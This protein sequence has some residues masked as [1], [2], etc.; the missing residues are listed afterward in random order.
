M[1]CYIAARARVVVGMA[2]AELVGRGPR[3]LGGAAALPAPRSPIR[4]SSSWTFSW[5]LGRHPTDRNAV[6][7]AVPRSA[8]LQA[9]TAPGPLDPG[10]GFP[11]IHGD[12]RRNPM[13]YGVPSPPSYGKMPHVGIHDD[14]SQGEHCISILTRYCPCLDSSFVLHV[15]LHIRGI[16]DLL[17]ELPGL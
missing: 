4:T 14:G 10:S 5:Q 6:L 11:R 8:G 7:M 3:G 16:S 12:G 2:D 9:D 13:G 17:D 1:A 15:L